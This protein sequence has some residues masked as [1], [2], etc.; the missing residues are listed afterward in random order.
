MPND[1][2]LQEPGRIDRYLPWSDEVPP[3]CRLAAGRPDEAVA[4]GQQ[5]SDRLIGCYI[6]TEHIDAFDFEAY[7]EEHAAELVNGGEVSPQYELYQ[8]RVYAQLVEE[9]CTDSDGETHTTWNY[10]FPELEG[11]AYF[12]PLIEREGESYTTFQ[13]GEGLQNIHNRINSTDGGNS[14]E[15]SA[16]LYVPIDTVNA[17]EE[18]F[19]YYMNP[20]YQSEDGSV[21]LVGGS[22]YWTNLGDTPGVEMSTKLHEE[23]TQTSNGVSTEM[24]N[25]VEIECIAVYVPVSVTIIQMAK[26]GVVLSVESFLPTELPEQYAVEDGCEYIIMET[27]AFGSEGEDVIERRTIAPDTE[28]Y[29]IYVLVPGENAFMTMVSSEVL[30]AE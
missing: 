6:T 24:V 7:F 30:W 16:T 9:V 26:D 14:I 28:D 10:A 11:V 4:N 5:V 23:F 21:Y 27:H 1:D 20:V 19:C 22:G 12:A 18:E 8:N 29:D 3:S 25:S 2:R 15:L 13:T 17:T